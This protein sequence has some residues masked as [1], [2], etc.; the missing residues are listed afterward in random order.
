MGLNKDL[1]FVY[2]NLL[3][4]QVVEVGVKILIFDWGKCCGKVRVVKSNWDVILFKIKKEQMDFDQDI[5]L[6]V[7]Y[8]NNQVQQFFIVNEVDK[9]V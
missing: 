8:F 4:N 2:Y 5:F 3:D 1:F 7:E 6:L 9:I